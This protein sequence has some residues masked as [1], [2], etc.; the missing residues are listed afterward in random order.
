MALAGIRSS[1]E[2][3]EKRGRCAPV[4]FA[5]DMRQLPNFRRGGQ[6]FF[7]KLLKFITSTQIPSL[8]DPCL[9]TRT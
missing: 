2:P 6:F 1:M 9:V 4:G 3:K 8:A 5:S 7:S